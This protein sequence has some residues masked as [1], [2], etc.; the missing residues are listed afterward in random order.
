MQHRNF[1]IFNELCHKTV[2]SPKQKWFRVA[3]TEILFGIIFH[4][5]GESFA[6]DWWVILSLRK[7]PR[8]AMHCQNRFFFY[9]WVSY[10]PF[11][12]FDKQQSM[13]WGHWGMRITLGDINKKRRRNRWASKQVSRGYRCQFLFLKLLK[14]EMFSV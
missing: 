8:T 13:Q 11:V 5:E 2:T 10:F 4:H 9:L 12:F 14:K 7:L 3:D 1:I 6:L